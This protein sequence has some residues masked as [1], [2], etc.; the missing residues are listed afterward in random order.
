ML[1]TDHSSQ[2][3]IMQEMLK[4]PLVSDHGLFLLHR[5]RFPLTSAW[6]LIFKGQRQVGIVARNVMLCFPFPQGGTSTNNVHTA[7]LGFVSSGIVDCLSKEGGSSCCKWRIC[8]SL[9]DA[10]TPVPPKLASHVGLGDTDPFLLYA[11]VNRSPEC[12]GRSGSLDIY[13]LS[14]RVATWTA[15]L[16]EVADR[17]APQWSLPSHRKKQKK[18]PTLWYTW[19]LSDLKWV[20]EQQCWWRIGAML[21]GSSE[22]E[23]NT[24]R[25]WSQ[26]FSSL[27]PLHQLI[28]TTGD[29]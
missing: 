29:V 9:T 4:D 15:G 7:F 5:Q 10:A 27:P 8:R 6:M 13:S 14:C 12:S 28:S 2:S 26:Q 21:S 17:A 25:R 1:F 20:V 19:E 3:W 11:K 24:I 23:Q 22:R 18:T 16:L